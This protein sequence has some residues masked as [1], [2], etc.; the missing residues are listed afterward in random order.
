ALFGRLA[1][2]PLQYGIAAAAPFVI[3]DRRRVWLVGL[4]VATAL[5]LHLFN[6]FQFPEP[7]LG[8][9]IDPKILDSLYTQAAITTFGLIAASVYYAFALVERAKAETETVLRNVLPDSVVERLK[10]KPEETIADGFIE[11]SVLFAD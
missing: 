1:G 2:T 8:R 7:S 10:A 5:C 11:A 3:F 6:W 9:H 4:I